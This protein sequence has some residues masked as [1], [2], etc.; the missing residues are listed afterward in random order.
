MTMAWINLR[1]LLGV[2]RRRGVEP[3]EVLVYV[4]PRDAARL[5]LGRPVAVPDL[6]DEQSEEAGEGEDENQEED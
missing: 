1:F 6:E 4:T 3:A 2:L 5:G